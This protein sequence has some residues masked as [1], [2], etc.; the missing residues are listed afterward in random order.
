MLRSGIN[1][2]TA[3]WMNSS[4][5]RRVKSDMFGC[6]FPLVW[7][8]LSTGVWQARTGYREQPCTGGWQIRGRLHIKCQSAERQLNCLIL[9]ISSGSAGLI[10]FSSLLFVKLFFF[11][12]LISA[13]LSGGGQISPQQ[14][15]SG[16]KTTHCMKRPHKTSLKLGGKMS[17]SGAFFCLKS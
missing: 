16:N 11:R 5:V 12:L 14:R 8:S 3:S 17:Y 10:C 2:T 13:N 15:L 1:L 7:F 6:L 9:I 4:K